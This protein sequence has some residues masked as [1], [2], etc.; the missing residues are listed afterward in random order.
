RADADEHLDEVRAGDGKERSVRF[1][2]DRAGQQ[3]LARSRRTHEQ[4]A[5]RDLAAELRELL[6]LFEELDDLVKLEL[7]FVDACHVLECDFLRGPGEKLRFRL[8]EG[9]S[10]VAA[11]LHLAHEEDPETDEEED[12]GPAEQRLDDRAVLLRLELHRDVVLFQ[13]IVKRRVIGGT[14]QTEL[15]LH[16]LR[17][18]RLQLALDFIAVNGDLVDLILRDAVDEGAVWHLL[19]IVLRVEELP[20]KNHQNDDDQPEERGLDCG[21]QRLA[22]KAQRRCFRRATPT[23]QLSEPDGWNG[24]SNLS[25][26][27]SYGPEAPGFCGAWPRCPSRKAGDVGEVAEPPVIFQSVTDE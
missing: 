22:S 6:R 21:I 15:T 14:G 19:G 11:S 7:R 1:A 10:L 27:E 5:F 12:R 25:M 17:R 26:G 8:A 2:C 13:E 24:N 9:E 3:C 4:H 18:G 16:T 20:E 23:L